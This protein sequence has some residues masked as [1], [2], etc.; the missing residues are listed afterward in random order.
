MRA[1]EPAVIRLTVD[2]AVERALAHAP[3]LRQ[4]GANEAAAEEAVLQA[5]ADGRPRLD[6][7]AGYTRY[8]NVPEFVVGIP[9]NTTPFFPNIPDNPRVRVSAS[10][11][12]YT[13]GRVE[14]LIESAGGE[15]T[16]AGER[17]EAARADLVL[18]TRRAYWALVTAAERVKVVS[19]NLTAF[20]AHLTDARNRE[21]FG[22]AARNEVL[23]VE[24]D[25]DRAELSRLRAETGSRIA[26]ANLAR[27]IGLDSGE[28]V[29]PVETLAASSTSV[30]DVETLVASAVANRPELAAIRGR[31]ASAQA[32][33]RVERSYRLPQLS[34]GAG[35][36]YAHPNPRYL[37][38]E[39][40]WN[41]NWEVGLSM[42]WSLFDGGRSSAGERRAG[43]QVEAIEAELAD[44]EER[45]RLDV[46]SARL[47]LENARAAVG[48]A[49][50]A[51]GAA[52]ESRRV[53]AE[54][55]REGVILSSELLDAEVAALRADLEHTEALAA[56]RLAAAALD[57]AVGSSYRR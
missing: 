48:L 57:H 5:R 37:P 49:D 25:R 19:E 29:E 47:E 31:L 20:E 53:A 6:L 22:L 45:I 32:Q 54:R 55:Y 43:A 8:S 4:L 33:A 7:S 17:L 26:A 24:V 12:L 51:R 27:L 10:Y 14:G 28:S 9:G 42:G 36:Y 30:E 2:D 46:V 23:A 39:P 15:R 44:L 16:S 35:V 50:R 21:R 1:Q 18:E 38:P 41:G 34:L 13:G 40:E 3:R 56:E 52:R 11:P